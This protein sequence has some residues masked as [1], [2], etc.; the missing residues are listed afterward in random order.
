VMAGAAAISSGKLLA[1][2]CNGPN[3]H[4]SDPRGGAAMWLLIDTPKSVSASLS[5]NGFMVA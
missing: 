2:S 1:A 4:S 5:C 3:V